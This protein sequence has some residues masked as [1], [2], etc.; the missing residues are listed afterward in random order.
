MTKAHEIYMEVL[1]N[2]KAKAK[3]DWGIYILYQPLP[4]SYWKDSASNGGNVLGLERFN[5]QVL[6]RKSSIHSLE[7]P[8]DLLLQYTNRTSLGREQSKMRF[9]RLPV[10]ASSIGS[11]I[12]LRA[13]RP[14]THICISTMRI[15]HRTP[16]QV[17]VQ[18]M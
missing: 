6:C 11:A 15:V 16:W 7:I 3:G 1:A 9:S 14:T 4:P 12:M 18:R 5:G 2:L 13:S 10:Q 8:A 17:T